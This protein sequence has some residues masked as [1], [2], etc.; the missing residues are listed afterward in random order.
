MGR[1]RL[2][3]KVNYRRL[4]GSLALHSPLKSGSKESVFHQSRMSVPAFTILKGHYW[5]NLSCSCFLSV[6]LV[7]TAGWVWKAYEGFLL[8]MSL[9]APAEPGGCPEAEAS[10]WGRCDQARGFLPCCKGRWEPWCVISGV[11]CWELVVAAVQT[12]A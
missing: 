2:P 4:E 7:V 6:R 3:V 12:H 9:A 10:S 1:P 11:V 5:G 8:H